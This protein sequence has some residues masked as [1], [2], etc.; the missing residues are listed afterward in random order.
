MHEHLVTKNVAGEVAAHLCQQV[1]KAL[2]GKE[3]STFT[4]VSTIV[5]QAMEETVS[6][7]LTPKSATDLLR[8]VDAC[9]Q[10]ATT[11][12]YV[13]AM[14]GVNGVGKSTNL[15]KLCFWLLQNKYS[16]LIA[17]CDTFRGGAVE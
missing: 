16:V 5:R 6:R 11:R 17:A 8:E 7:L 2:V 4:S 15:S 3:V 1:E 9:K 10:S 12:P 13:I 14:I